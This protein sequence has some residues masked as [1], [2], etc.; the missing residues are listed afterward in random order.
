M[1]PPVAVCTAALVRWS[2]SVRNSFTGCMILPLL[3]WYWASCMMVRA[4]SRS[5]GPFLVK[6][7]LP[8]SNKPLTAF[9]AI[10][11]VFTKPSELVWASCSLAN[12]CSLKPALRI[13]SASGT[14][15]PVDAGTGMPAATKSQ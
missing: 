3:R 10:T 9:M 6:L 11:S 13:S 14:L 2:S 1:V 8:S 15:G 4:I 12:S 5:G 7:P